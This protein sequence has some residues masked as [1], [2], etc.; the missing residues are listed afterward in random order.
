MS[1]RNDSKIPTIFLEHGGL[2]VLVGAVVAFQTPHSI[3]IQAWQ[4]LCM[5]IQNVKQD[6]WMSPLIPFTV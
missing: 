1:A 3:R 5:V 6:S 2:Q 4:T